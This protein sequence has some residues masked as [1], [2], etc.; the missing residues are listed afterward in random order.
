[1][2]VQNAKYA[3][4]FRVLFLAATFLL[5]PGAWAQD[6]APHIAPRQ[7]AKISSFAPASVTLPSLTARPMR[8][9]V[10]LVL[11]PVTVVDS[12]SRP[13]VDLPQK[14]FSLL[15]GGVPQNIQY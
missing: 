6:D 5:A 2:I 10:N 9:D 1:M 4:T 8:V 11:V 7:N 12:T 13:V 15:E 3:A 14:N